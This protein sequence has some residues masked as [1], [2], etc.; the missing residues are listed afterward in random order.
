MVTI[1][2][3]PREVLLPL[4]EATGLSAPGMVWGYVAAEKQE[5]AGYCVVAEPD[6]PSGPCRILTLDAEDK[7]IA[8]GLLRRA[9]HPFYEEGYAEYTFDLPPDTTMLP[10]YIIIGNGSLSK[11]F[12]PCPAN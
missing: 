3:M 8:D 5:M 12:K 6:T 4:C 2:P 7:F 9:L 11:L 10:D 1:L